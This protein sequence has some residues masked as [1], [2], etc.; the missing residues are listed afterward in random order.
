MGEI[1]P[2]TLVIVSILGIGFIH[3]GYSIY[4]FYKYP[5]TTDFTKEEFENKIISDNRSKKLNNILKQ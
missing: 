3:A 4:E 1:K 2:S 5:I